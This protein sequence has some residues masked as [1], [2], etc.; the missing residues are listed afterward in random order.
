ME[1]DENQIKTAFGHLLL[2]ADLM[3]KRVLTAFDHTAKRAA[4]VKAISKF[5]LEIL[6]VCAKFLGI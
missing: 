5:N 3:S 1:F 2:R 4:N 6:E